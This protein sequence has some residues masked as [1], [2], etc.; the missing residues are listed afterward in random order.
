MY[1]TG[2]FYGTVDFDP[3]PGNSNTSAPFGGLFILKLDSQGNF[4]WVKQLDG[5]GPHFSFVA[6]TTDTKNNVYTTGNFRSTTDFDPG[7]GISN[8]TPNGTDSDV[9]IQKLNANGDFLWAIPIGST[10]FD[11]SYSILTDT[12]HN[13]YT[14]GYYG[15]Q[16]DFDPSPGTAYLTSDYPV[17][18]KLSQ[19]QS[20][21]TDIQTACNS[22]TWLDGVTYTSS[23]NTATY[24]IPGGGANGC[25]SIITLD[26]TI[27]EVSDITTTVNGATI[28]ANNMN[29]TSYQW[30]NCN[31]GM[32]II[33]GETASSLT[34]LVNGD[35]AVEITENGCIDTSA[36]VTI[37]LSGIAD[38]LISEQIKIYPNPTSSTFTI[39]FESKQENVSIKL[40]SI[41]GQ[42]IEI[43]T[44]EQINQAEMILDQPQGIFLIEILNDKG[45]KQIIR[46]NKIE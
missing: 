36:C 9:F 5:L 24:L 28:N 19:C 23:N 7:P 38:H 18:Q 37:I 15:N 34:T 44:F 17:I 27:N 1:V 31:S 42:L 33:Q 39:Q 10:S 20:T 41:A 12:N 3:G 32:S 29:A 25:D 46:L 13:I 4:L 21:Y 22:Y 40:W 2:R 26:L 11:Y 30:L 35:Y 14:T 16:T 8:L 45:E 43:R 6:I